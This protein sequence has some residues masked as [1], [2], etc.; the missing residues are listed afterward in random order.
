MPSPK[1]RRLN[2]LVVDDSAIVREVMQ[3]ILATDEFAVTTAADPII[4]TQKLRG[5]RPDVVI[6]DLAMPRMDGLSFLRTIMADDPLPVVVCSA[7]AQLGSADTAMRAL[8]EGAVDI[9]AKPRMGVRGFLEDSAT[10]LADTLRAAAQATIRKRA[11]HRNS[12][13]PPAPPKPAPSAPRFLL[14][15]SLVAL[16]ASTG[17]TEALAALLS[18]LPEDAPGVVVVQ[19]MPEG[20]TEA[21]ARRLNGLSPMRVR[22][23]V[24]GDRIEQGLALIA[25]GG[26]HTMVRQSAGGWQVRVADGPL[27][28]RHRPSIDVLFQSVAEAAGAA[29]VGVLMT[30]MGRDGSQGLAAMKRRGAWT[31]AQDEGSC[32]VFGMPKEAIALGAASEVLPLSRIAAA[33]V[34]RT[35]ASNQPVAS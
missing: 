20:F 18:A 21:F 2:V 3:Q 26:R 22:E 17:G 12:R 1:R 23:A 32:V 13:R 5:V 6:L 28:S 11:S 19:H 14:S 25:P 10:T 33:I 35:V 7:L 27:L 8:A 15:E 30:G 4:A 9:V 29:S 16:G 34:A 24:D 31:I